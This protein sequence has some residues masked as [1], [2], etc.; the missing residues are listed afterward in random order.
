MITCV[1]CVLLWPPVLCASAYLVGA[2]QE[3]HG[4]KPEKRSGWCQL[5]VFSGSQMAWGAERSA[6]LRLGGHVEE[7]DQGGL[8]NVRAY[9]SCM[10]VCACAC[11]DGY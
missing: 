8:R 10:C 1:F 2:R 3:W 6:R 9:I 7:G 11:V 4:T 5:A